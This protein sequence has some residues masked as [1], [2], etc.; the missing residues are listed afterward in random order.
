MYIYRLIPILLSLVFFSCSKYELPEGACAEREV[1]YEN[2]LTRIQTRS[3]EYTS[4][5]CN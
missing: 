3:I 2:G 1:I 5:Q 4:E